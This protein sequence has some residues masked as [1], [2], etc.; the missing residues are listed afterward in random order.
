MAKLT[1]WFG[2]PVVI[3]YVRVSTDEQSLDA[4]LAVFD[5]NHQGPARPSLTNV[6]PLEVA[7]EYDQRVLAEN[8]VLVNMAQGP[9]IVSFVGEV[10]Q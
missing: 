6:A 1:Q 10:R 4:R 8:F 2:K 7:R 9:V 5:R 3:G